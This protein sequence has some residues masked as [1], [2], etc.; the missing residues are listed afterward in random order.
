MSDELCKVVF[1]GE[2]APGEDRDA[3]RDRVAERFRM[4]IER[5][6]ALFTGKPVVIKRGIDQATAERLA[7]AFREVGAVCE[8]R[9]TGAAPETAAQASPASTHGA[10]TTPPAD[11]EPQSPAPSAHTGPDTAAGNAP[12]TA[13]DATRSAAPDDPNQTIVHLDVPGDVSHLALDDATPYTPPDNDV[14]APDIDTSGLKVVDDE[15]PLA[16]PDD[17]TAPPDIDTS[18]LEIEM[19]THRG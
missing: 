12:S 5:A 16:P 19:E 18:G 2:I 6:E 10:Q 7:H 11:P 13:P 1:R 15:A 17:S 14:P 3:V 9:G 4:S 8:V